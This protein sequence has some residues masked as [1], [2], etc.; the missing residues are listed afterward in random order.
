MKHTAAR[1]TPDLREK[2]AMHDGIVFIYT[3]GSGNK[4]PWRSLGGDWGERWCKPL[5]APLEKILPLEEIIYPSELYKPGSIIYRAIGVKNISKTTLYYVGAQFAHNAIRELELQYAGKK[6]PG[7]IRLLRCGW[8]K[9]PVNTPP[10]PI[11]DEHQE[12]QGIIWNKPGKAV[13]LP[14][15]HLRPGDVKGLWLKVTV[16]KTKR[17]LWDYDMVALR[18]S[19][20]ITAAEAYKEEVI[21]AQMD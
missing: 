1:R 18:I 21:N 5:D 11:K 6:Y 7:P 2:A 9:E 10:S 15:Q 8:A 14:E 3:G 17:D 13:A 12:P 4:D 20:A 19:Y 16:P